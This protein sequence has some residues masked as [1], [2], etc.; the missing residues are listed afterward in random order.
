MAKPCWFYWSFTSLLEGT[1]PKE[2]ETDPKEAETWNC[3]ERRFYRVSWA[4]AD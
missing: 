4:K 1:G 3:K 2:S